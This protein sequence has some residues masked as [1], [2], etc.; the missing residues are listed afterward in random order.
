MSPR[1]K[2]LSSLSLILT[3]D[4]ITILTAYY[5]SYLV[6]FDFTLAPAIFA[7]FHDTLILV[8][9]VKIPVFYLFKLYKGMWRFTGITDLFNVIKASSCASAGICLFLLYFNRFQGFSRSVFV[10][11]WFLTILL[12]S[13]FRVFVR[14]HY[15]GRLLAWLRVLIPRMGPRG[16]PFPIKRLL[17]VGAGKSGEKIYREIIDNHELSYDVIGFVDDHPGKTGKS[18]HGKSVLGNVD[19]LQE[20]ARK[21]QADEIII[22]ISSATSKQM[23]RIVNLCKETDVPYKT[24][25]GMGEI[26]SGGVSISTIRDVSY[27]DLLGR[28]NIRLD[29]E[30]IQSTLTGSRI[31][32]T[33]AGGSIGSELCR[34]ICRFAPKQLVLLERAETPLYDIDMELRRRFPQLDII[35]LMADIQ[36][37]DQLEAAFALHRPDVVLHAAAYKHVPMMENHPWKAIKNNI[38]GTRNLVDVAARYQ[39]DRFV[40]VSTDKAVRPTNVMGATKRIAELL[41]LNHNTLSRSQTKFMA[42]RFGN[43]VGSAGSVLP[44]FKKQIEGGGPVTVTHKDITRYFMTI[45]EATQLILQAGAM[46]QG[47]EIFILDMGEPVKIDSLARDFIRL[48]GFE[49]D[50]DMDIQYIGLRPGEKLFEELI[51]EGEGIVP[52]KHRK[53]M[54][55]RGKSND[56]DELNQALN[57]LCHI[58]RN[59]EKSPIRKKL[60][61]ILPEYTPP[62]NGHGAKEQACTTGTSQG[63]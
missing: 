8:L 20:L 18:I 35:P 31:L 63:S 37:E 12:I 60:G 17:I 62:R 29:Q 59:Q 14:V 42:V 16:R 32:V 23:R 26:I 48:S 3:V 27:N 61:E 19:Q 58:A 5:L 36:H 55:L 33:G 4:I 1:T 25:P 56:L 57:E 6:R 39:V 11:D 41:V 43:V 47:G 28:D 40:L 49:P 24:I 13:G 34:Q 44:L 52:T 54:V 53:I 7:G 22:A 46:G 45:P 9:A 38:I 30:L 10:I 2:S 15:E 51:T 21:L 50:V